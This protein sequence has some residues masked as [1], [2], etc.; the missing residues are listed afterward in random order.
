L[1]FRNWPELAEELLDI[2]HPARYLGAEHGAVP[3]NEPDERGF[4][5]TCAL[6]FPEVYEIAHCHLGHKI[7]YHLFNHQRGFSAE[8]VY[9][10]W[11]D[12]EERL[13]KAGRALRSLENKRPL[14]DF[15]VVGFS[16][17]YELSY[18]NILN[19]LSLGGINPLRAQRDEDA[20]LIVAGGPGAANPEGLA[21]F[22]DLF[23]LGEA[24]DTWL[25]DFTIIKD[26]AFRKEPKK[27]LFDRLAGRPG[28]YIPSLFEPQ[29]ENDKFT[30]LECLKPGYSRVSRAAVRDLT[31]APFPLCQISPWLKPVHNRVVVE[32]ARGCSRGCR[33]CQAGYIYRP[34]R[35]RE[36]NKVLEL[37]RE[38][39]TATGYDEAA[40]LSLSAGDHTQI[41]SLVSSFMNTWSDSE[42]AL[43]LPSLRVK[44][45]SQNLAGEIARV[46]KTGFTIAPEAATARLRA[47]INKDLT[48]DDLLAA[49]T[50][51]FSYGWRTLKLYFLTGLPTETEE[52]LI[53]LGQ[54]AGKVKKLSRARIN[55]SVATFVPKAHTPFQW[56]AAS[57]FS[58]IDGRF[59]VFGPFFKKTGL[60]LKYSSPE[61]SVLEGILARGDRRLGRVFY[62]VFLKGA[63][64]EAWNERLNFSLWQEALAYFGRQIPELLAERDPAAPLPWDHL[65]PFVSRE[66]LQRELNK[67]QRAETTPDCRTGGCQNCGA[68][69]GVSPSLAE[70]G[71]VQPDRGISE[72]KDQGDRKPGTGPK[73]RRNLKSA[74]GGQPPETFRYLAEFSKTGPMALLGHLEMV[75]VIKRCIRRSGLPMAFSQG[76]HPQM[77]LGFLTAP[78][79]GM[80]SLSELMIVTLKE[81]RSPETVRLS[82]ILPPGLDILKVYSLP[83]G[84][85]K[86]KIGSISYQIESDYSIWTSQPL[87]PAA[88]LSYTDKQGRI[89]VFDLAKFI[90]VSEVLDPCQLKLTILYSP[91][92]SPR[93]LAAARALY[94]LGDEVRLR[95]KKTATVLA[96]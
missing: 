80:E 91:E 13:K 73:N 88:L 85:P 75:E 21:D 29:Y 39:L 54:L 23:F 19:M 65:G 14:N 84:A 27:E 15:H 22:F 68:C 76:F 64:F 56:Q 83:K 63:R 3:G 44:S 2:E 26:W 51:A 78:P 95:V 49:C 16:L 60:D 34:V 87:H 28:I 4:I 37:T 42:V 55:V 43:S 67:A 6:A 70:P 94:G 66:F 79:L 12:Y 81:P 47:V 35:E 32:I 1:K 92:G 52:D 58:D 71:H 77:K 8:R 69:D 82:L 89:R 61:A 46:R 20:P 17:Q 74:P 86:L 10:P 30:G 25:G 33:F 93:P 62:E 9:A 90:Q 53:A 45:L 72:V 50:A 36:Q 57:N 96:A 24:E 18:T 48:E 31:G 40:F 5:L 7:L 38:N 11:V 41:E 59:K